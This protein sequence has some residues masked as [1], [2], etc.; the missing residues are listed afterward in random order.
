MNLKDMISKMR[1]E[2]FKSIVVSAVALGLLC[3][4]PA[5]LVS[6]L[7]SSQVE[8]KD[9]KKVVDI[10][11]RVVEIPANPKSVVSI[12]ALPDAMVARLRPDLQ[13]T[14]QPNY[15]ARIGLFSQEE[16]ARLKA[17]PVVNAFYKPTSIDTIV[18]VSPD[19][20]FD[21]T[22]D[23]KLE[24]RQQEL[25][26]PVVALDK[27]TIELYTTSWR[28]AG[29]VLGA[30]SEA[31]SVADY[32]EASIAETKDKV[33]TSTIKN[34]RMWL[35][36]G[37]NGETV[38]PQTIQDSLMKAAGGT[39][40]WATTPSLTQ[41]PTN[42]ELAVP[43]EELLKF[44]PEY[45]FCINDGVRKAIMSDGRLKDLAAV[46][47]GHVWTT[48]KYFRVDQSQTSIAARWIATKVYS[49]VFTE[50]DL[51]TEAVKFYKIVFRADVNEENPLF[52]ELNK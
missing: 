14:V 43:V 51:L 32:I 27:D 4:I 35:A 3:A 36:T 21:I 22:K 26:A 41:D 19:I 31:N 1:T 46:K 11:G 39:T 34:P 49:D 16:Q 28:I 47:A 6:E 44:N 52:N 7:T 2:T 17:L 50:K 23:P 8:T 12:H 45:I 48:L 38:G 25:G 29:K 5:Y 20:V 42:E 18:S 9:T 37:I 13:K 24:S 40:Y 30:E 33:A 10:A 15:L